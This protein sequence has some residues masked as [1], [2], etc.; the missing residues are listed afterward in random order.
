MPIENVRGRI[1]F[2]F[3]LKIEK[4]IKHTGPPLFS[5]EI[6]IIQDDGICLVK[7][8]KRTVEVNKPIYIGATVLDL[9]KLLMYKFHYQTMKVKYPDALMVNTDTDSLLYYIKT[10]AALVTSIQ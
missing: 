9:S 3:C 8:N 6:N 1:N 2:Q 7:T 5:N 4:V 10:N